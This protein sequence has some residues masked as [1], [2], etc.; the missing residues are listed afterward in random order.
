M[1]GWA[2]RGSCW[3]TWCWRGPGRLDG[4]P[5][6]R[7]DCTAGINEW[8]CGGDENTPHQSNMHATAARR[9]EPDG[10]FVF[11]ALTACLQRSFC[12]KLGPP[13]D[14]ILLREFCRETGM[15]N[16]LRWQ[17]KFQKLLLRLQQLLK[18]L[19]WSSGRH[20]F[21]YMHYFWGPDGGT[22]TWFSPLLLLMCKWH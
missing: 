12:S 19:Q 6:L 4:R 2:I 8:G 16:W 17:S 1:P 21:A 3:Q 14:W 10:G 9:A 5:R 18:I 15:R 13:G 7:S 20:I 11:S 22:D